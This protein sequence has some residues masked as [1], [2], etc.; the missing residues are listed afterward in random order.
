MGLLSKLFSRKSSPPINTPEQLA[1]ALGIDYATISGRS[2]SDIKAMQL[3]TVFACVRVLSESVGMLPCHLYKE[4]AKQKNKA[5]EHW[6]Y[7]LINTAPNDYMTAQEF[8]ELL[9]VSLC[10][11]GNFYAYKNKIGDKVTELLPIDPGCVE[12]KLN[13]SWEPVYKVTFADGSQDVLSQ[14]EIWHVRIFTKDGL[15]GLSPIAYA[16]EAIG[17]ALATEEH[18]SRLFTNG[19][20]TTGV[21]ST[22]QV[23]SDAAFKR[24]QDDFKSRHQGLANSHKP[25]ILEMGLDWKSISLSAEDS[26]FLE[27]RKFQRDEICAIF[28]VPPHLVA[29]LDKASFNNIEHLGLSFI[30]YSLVPYLTRIENRIK[31]GLLPK[32]QQADT[33]AKFNVGALLRGDMKS[34]FEAYATAINWGMYS[35]NDCLR[36]EDQNPRPGGDVYLT[37]LNMTSGPVNPTGT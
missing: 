9:I 22:E 2:V 20:V 25:L 4:S 36:L 26:Q 24:L 13:A 5:K 30:N 14:D 10:L 27:S 35:P 8:W 37:P 31:V 12:A 23:L 11:R 7:R 6:L 17:L 28:R 15:K 32:S 3:T 18:G 21:L 1:Q 19:A 29:N 33:F 16:K 34:R